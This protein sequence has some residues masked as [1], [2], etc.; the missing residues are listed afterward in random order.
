MSRLSSWSG[1]TASQSRSSS[2]KACD[3]TPGSSLCSRHKCSV[4]N[5]FSP[6]Y[7]Q[8]GG[9]DWFC[10][11]HSYGRNGIASSTATTI[12]PA[13]ALPKVVVPTRKPV[14]RPAS[15]L[16]P[17]TANRCYVC[18][19]TKENE[20]HICSRHKCRHEYCQKPRYTPPK[21]WEGFYCIDHYGYVPE[22]NKKKAQISQPPALSQVKTLDPKPVTTSPVTNRIIACP[23]CK[24]G[25]R[26][27]SLVLNGSG[28]TFCSRHRCTIAGCVNERAQTGW[29]CAVHAVAQKLDAEKKKEEDEMK[30]LAEKEIIRTNTGDQT[31][32]K[33]WDSLLEKQSKGGA[34]MSWAK[35]KRQSLLKAKSISSEKSSDQ[36]TIEQT[37]TDT[38]SG[39][40]A[41]HDERPD[42]SDTSS[43]ND[44]SRNGTKAAGNTDGVVK[45]EDEILKV[46]PRR[47]R[48]GYWGR[49]HGPPD[50]RWPTVSDEIWVCERH[51]S[52]YVKDDPP[53][54]L[55]CPA[56]LS[57]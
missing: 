4:K 32:D 2:C 55:D 33:T 3:S 43:F 25:D 24:T 20:Y 53:V 40:S 56:S 29:L 50:C 15:L 44:M 13:T 36:A 41:T 9:S 46:P 8:P 54:S 18:S 19:P 14:E 51:M 48:I 28:G 5:C 7:S 17:L 37:E 23:R 30:R 6:R 42:P 39:S 26:A 10:A 45:D 22:T 52:H 12:P 21:G 27:G 16:K 47:K 57:K 34:L 11:S 38:K 1:N 31:T 35:S 49:C